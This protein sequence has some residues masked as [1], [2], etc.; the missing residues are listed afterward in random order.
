MERQKKDI[1]NYTSR[2][3]RKGDIEREREKERER[4]GG[5]GER[6]NKSYNAFN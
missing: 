2:K 3:W 5:G 1:L 4:E 6:G